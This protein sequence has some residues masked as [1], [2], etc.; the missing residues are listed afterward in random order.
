MGHESRKSGRGS[1]FICASNGEGGDVCGLLRAEAFFLDAEMGNRGQYPDLARNPESGWIPGSTGSFFS[2]QIWQVAKHRSVFFFSSLSLSLFFSAMRDAHIQTQTSM[3]CAGVGWIELVLGPMFSGKTTELLR[4]IRR[5]TVAKK[6]C[7][8]VKHSKDDRY[9]KEKLSTHD[10][11]SRSSDRLFL[12]HCVFS[13][14]NNGTRSR[15][16]NSKRSGSASTSPRTTS[17]AS[18]RPS[19]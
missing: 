17:S 8:I 1:T 18:T 12:T 6:R 16:K 3:E 15:R 2:D 9:S 19:S 4:R 11:L 10:M 5:Y 7:L 13:V 14:G